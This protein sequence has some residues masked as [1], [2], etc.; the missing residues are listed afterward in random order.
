MAPEPRAGDAGV[1]DD[2]LSNAIGK[3]LRSTWRDDDG[4]TLVFDDGEA[5]RI[6]VTR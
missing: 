5:I 6:D 1:G 2:P 3:T 4:V